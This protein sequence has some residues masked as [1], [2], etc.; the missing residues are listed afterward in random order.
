MI[1]IGSFLAE[2]ITVAAFKNKHYKGLFAWGSPA[3]HHRPWR[4]GRRGRGL[5]RREGKNKP[6]SIYTRQ[7]G[8]LGL[9]LSVTLV[10]PPESDEYGGMM[11]LFEP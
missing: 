6:P 2:D 4:V 3:L 9:S 8:G 11:P 1:P 5:L 10:T 7:N